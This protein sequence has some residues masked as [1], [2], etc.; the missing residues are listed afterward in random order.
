MTTKKMKPPEFP[1]PYYWTKARLG[2][3]WRRP[4]GIDNKYRHAFKGYPPTVNV[5][6]RTP[7][8]TRGLHPCGLIPVRVSSVSELD[9]I[10]PK[11]QCVIIASTVGAQKFAMIEAA[12]IQKG[13]YVVNGKQK[14][15]A[16]EG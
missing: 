3:S 16:K 7:K 5:G 6:Y 14:E 8:K 13:I 11:T 15:K 4:K 10:D 12:A 9:S 2:E 1:R